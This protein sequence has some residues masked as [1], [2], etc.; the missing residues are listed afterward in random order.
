MCMT[1]ILI[2]ILLYA[3]AP[4]KPLY[5]LGIEYREFDNKIKYATNT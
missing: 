1:S 3:I 2:T 4:E 5:S